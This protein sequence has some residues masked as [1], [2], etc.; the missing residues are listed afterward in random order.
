M[1]Q[2]AMRLSGSKAELIFY[3]THG[4]T[5]SSAFDPDVFVDVEG[6]LAEKL[7]IIRCHRCQN[8]KN[9]QKDILVGY[10]LLQMQ[11]RGGQVGRVYAEG[12]KFRYPPVAGQKSVL[13]GG[14]PA[15]R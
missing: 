1:T 8:A 9:G 3:E 10:G 13:L 14:L 2:K 5:Q 6:V 11:F 4:R 12:F 15:G 7:R